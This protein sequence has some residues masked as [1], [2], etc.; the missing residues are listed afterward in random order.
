MFLA[1]YEI[2]CKVDLSAYLLYIIQAIH[3]Q[4]IHMMICVISAIQQYLCACL[5]D[6]VLLN[7]I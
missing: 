2:T 3:I 5:H 7:A 4:C 1:L 6:G